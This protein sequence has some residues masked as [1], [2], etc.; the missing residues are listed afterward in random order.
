MLTEEGI[1]AFQRILDSGLPQVI[2]STQDL[3]RIVEAKKRQALHLLEPIAEAEQKQESAASALHQR[4]ELKSEYVAPSTE[5]EKILAAIWSKL[6][7][8]GQ[9]GIHDNFFELGG[10]SVVSIQ[11]IAKAN[12]AG[13][14]LTPKQVFEH[15]TI[16]ELVSPC[17]PTQASKME[18]D[19][20]TGEMPLTPIQHWFF[21]Q[22]F[23]DPHHFNVADGRQATG[24]GR[25]AAQVLGHLLDQ[26]PALRMRYR[27]ESTQWRQSITGAIEEVP[28]QRVDLSHIPETSQSAAVLQTATEMQASLNLINGPLLRLV[29]MDLGG[30]QHGRLL[31]VVHH[32]V[33]DAISWR[34]LLEDFYQAWNQIMLDAPSSWRQYDLSSAGRS[35]SNNTRS[36]RRPVKNW[37]TGSMEPTTPLC[38]SIQPAAKTRPAARKRCSAL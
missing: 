16:A 3:L 23:A 14:K 38:P 34:I 18:E 36:R 13:L 21:E 4:P 29:Y 25:R 27:R 28:Y 17:R 35:V 12:Q 30:H 5:A 6:L 7:G 2:V 9:I 22:E 11:I 19:I 33:M 20:E 10:D 15:Q 1:D 32:L 31:F 8:I 24:R 37:I 26:H